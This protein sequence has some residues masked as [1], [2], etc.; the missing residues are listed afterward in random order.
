MKGQRDPLAE[1]L[2]QLPLPAL[3]GATAERVRA[4]AAAHLASAVPP[5]AVARLRLA[6][7]GAAVPALLASAATDQAA[8]TVT[9]ANE[10][11]KKR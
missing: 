8:Q 5:R 1:A 4:Q 6:L 9:A 11:F 2:D 3:D 7:A 10:V